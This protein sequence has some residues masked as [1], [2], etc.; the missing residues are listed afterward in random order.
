ML[1]HFVMVC[2]DTSTR[3]T[4]PVP[5]LQPATEQER[6]W[7]MAAA[8]LKEQLQKNSQ[9][10]ARYKSSSLPAPPVIAQGTPRILTVENSRQSKTMLMHPQVSASGTRFSATL[11]IVKFR[12]THGK[13]FGGFVMN[14]AYGLAFSTAMVA[15][16]SMRPRF[17]SLE[18]SSFVKPVELGNILSLDANVIYSKGTEMLVRV[19]ADV[20]EPQSGLSRKLEQ[21]ADLMD[22]VGRRDTTNVFHLIF[23]VG[24]DIQLYAESSFGQDLYQIG[25]DIMSR[26]RLRHERVCLHESFLLSLC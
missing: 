3:K 21:S 7:N 20:I 26:H 25:E 10:R 22:V 5:R 2:L 4:T 17:K 14:E 11:L 16:G 18:D 19:C 9:E 6:R 15:S 24:K 8:S 12:N 1:A 13:I 23:D